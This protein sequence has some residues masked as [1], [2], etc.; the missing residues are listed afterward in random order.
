MTNN[1]DENKIPYFIEIRGCINCSA[2]KHHKKKTGYDY[3]F[4]HESM[5]GCLCRCS[6]YTFNDKSISLLNPYYDPEEMVRL[7]KKDGRQEVI[8]NTE[9]L[10]LSIKET[11]GQFYDEMGVSL[12]DIIAKL[13]STD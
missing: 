3:G 6:N 12:D 7:A 8:N 10:C 1:A 5:F 4:D 13:H 9:K 11:F 2:S